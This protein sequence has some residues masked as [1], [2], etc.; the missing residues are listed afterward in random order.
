MPLDVMDAYA[1]QVVPEKMAFLDKGRNGLILR[2]LHHGGHNVVNAWMTMGTRLQSG[3][4]KNIEL[5]A[6]PTTDQIRISN[7]GHEKDGGEDYVFLAGKQN[8]E[9]AQSTT[10]QAGEFRVNSQGPTNIVSRESGVEVRSQGL[11][12]DIINTATGDMAPN[13][14]GRRLT[15]AGGGDAVWPHDADSDRLYRQST[16][17][18][19][20]AASEYDNHPDPAGKPP[21]SGSN[22]LDKG[23]ETWGCINIISEKNNI[24]LEALAPDSVIHINAPHTDSKIVVTTAGTVDIIAK[25]KI[26]ITSDE[27]IELNA[28]YVDINSSERVDID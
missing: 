27:K 2:D 13:K 1:N 21:G 3:D 25:Q 9:G 23:S 14:E 4:G 8:G 15:E 18:D 28:P 5:D 26:S 22:P 12:I 11:N 10:V 17:P 19:L 6:T 7:G 16:F 20:P 24:S